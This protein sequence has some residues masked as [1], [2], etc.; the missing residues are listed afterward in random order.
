[1]TTTPGA[2]VQETAQQTGKCRFSS[3]QYHW[4]IEAGILTTDHKVELIG[5]EILPMP[6]M[7][8]NHGDSISDL[9]LWLSDHRA[10]GYIPRCQVT[11]RLAE[12][13]TPDPDFTLL[14]YREDGY[15][16]HHRPNAGDVMLIIEVSDSSLALDLGPKGMA[17]AQAG[18][19]ELWVV[20]LPNK[21]I[22]KFTQPSPEGYGET[23]TVAED[24]TIIPLLIPNL[25]LPVR[26]AL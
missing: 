18:I 13:F 26:E 12:G 16:P 23:T 15:G 17:Y 25:Q 21:Q 7:G 3:D 2:S 1:M 10:Q 19:P 22:H 4:L 8:D 24:E 5:G 20:D 9:A 14:R 6:P 11:I